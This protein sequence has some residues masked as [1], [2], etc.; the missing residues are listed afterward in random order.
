MYQ[1]RSRIPAVSHDQPI[2]PHPTPAV[3][4]RLIAALAVPALA[5][6]AALL[7]ASI[8]PQAQATQPTLVETA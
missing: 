3:L 8:A 1:H 4:G 7:A 6:A 5:L 2:A